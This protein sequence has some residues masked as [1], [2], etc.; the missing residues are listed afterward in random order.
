MEWLAMKRNFFTKVVT[1]FAMCLLV[2]CGAMGQAG[3]TSIHGVVTDKS[4][5]VIAAAKVTLLN[6]A[7][8]LQRSVDSAEAG[9][10]EFVA[11]QP[12]TYT[13]VVEASGFRKFEQKS[14][15][16]LVNLP[17]TVNVTLE[18]GSAAQTIEV[19]GTTQTINT[20]D[21]SLG[22]AFN[23][24]QVK[25]LP[26]EGR[27]VPDLLSLQ[28]GV[29]YTGNRT[30]V[31]DFDTRSGAVNGARSDQ[32]NVTV[33]GIGA[34]DEGGKAFSS[35]LP[36]TLDSV[37]EFRVTTSNY[38]AD[39]GGSSGAQVALVTKSGTNSFHG[40]A[41]EYH[42][43]TY[44]SAND[45]FVKAA[46]LDG[47]LPNTPPKLIRNIFGGS[48]GGPV[49]KDRLYFFTNFEGTR[50]AEA[51]S[52][53]VQVP[54]DTMR[55]GIIQYLCADP[56]TCPGGT[57]T[58]S[59]G[60]SYAVQSGYQALS[61]GQLTAIDPL[62][63]GPNSPVMAY[64][65]TFPTPNCN[66]TGDGVN[67]S[68]FNFAAPISDTSNI[69]IAK[70]DYNITKDGKHRLSVSGS[71]INDNYAKAPF[72]PG[73]APTDDLVNY[74]KGIIASYSAVLTNNIVNN[75]RYGFVRQ[76]SGDIG[77]SNED[78]IFFRGLNDQA[79]AV[80]RSTAFQRPVHNFV[81]D[82][83]W[84][85]GRHTFQFGTQISIAREPRLS[86]AASFSDGSAN[87]SWTDTSGFAGK[88]GSPLNPSNNG[89][90]DVDPSFANSYDYPI[91]ALLGIVTEVDAKY[92]F[93]KDGSALPDGAALQ[94]RFGLDSYEFYLQ[95]TWKVKPS[96]TLT[97]GLR[98]SRSSRRRGKPT[99]WKLF[100][101]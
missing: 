63:L 9:E 85:R 76:S 11:L 44:T 7:Q 98:Y 95:D 38:N 8:G 60:K 94:R 23:E 17:S 100:R 14:V 36:V 40:S 49:I 97:L 29:A 83:S 89:L 53:T 96:L 91:Q 37:Q 92:N 6:P 54:S 33:D 69:Y 34:N 31:P 46:Q 42:R 26:L 67:Y 101:T 64:L 68:C 47:G 20:T 32:S 93:Q 73:E 21:A 86:T 90:P 27:N 3:T 84:T 50:R 56:S 4:G 51:V 25:Q 57:V 71:L 22:N 52:Q 35:V 1:T 77:N 10:F 16:L 13:L 65:N 61:P 88:S 24:N 59:S 70:M 30:D 45:Y 55:D 81:D 62:H 18:V 80:T 39:Q 28:P 75:F 87:A 66:N 41:Y 15:Q 43:N 79:G 19:S 58:G 99:G 78:W 2:V 82:V 48:L 72:L 74:S 5:A 12:G